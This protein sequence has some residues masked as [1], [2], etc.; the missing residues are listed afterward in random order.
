MFNI[1][2]ELLFNSVYSHVVFHNTSSAI[3]IFL[4]KCNDALRCYL[5]EHYPLIIST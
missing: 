1:N 2:I 5:D 3:N 4:N